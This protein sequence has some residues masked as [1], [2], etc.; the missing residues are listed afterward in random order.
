[1]LYFL[2]KYKNKKLN[3]TLKKQHIKNIKNIII[4]TH[5]FYNSF[6]LLS[7]LLSLFAMHVN[8]FLCVQCV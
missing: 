1:M 7:F 8:C 5:Y 2:K 4:L 6:F 3:K